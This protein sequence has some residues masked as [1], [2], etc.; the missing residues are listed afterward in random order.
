MMMTL[1]RRLPLSGIMILSLLL[2]SVGLTPAQIRQVRRSDQTPNG[3]S[4]GRPKVFDNRTLTIML[5]SLS[6]SLRNV[7]SQFIDQKALAAAFNFLQG[8]RSSEVVRSLSI[9]TLP[10]PSLK[11]ES[12]NTSGNVTADGTALPDSSTQTT[13]A[14]RSGFTPKRLV[15]IT[16]PPFPGLAPLLGQTLPIC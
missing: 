6:E 9:S 11:Q 14:E 5:E 10:I 15:L 1:F 13:T 4:V 3:I 16:L 8:S 2:S 12:I 7:Q